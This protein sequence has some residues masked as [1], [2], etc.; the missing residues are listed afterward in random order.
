MKRTIQISFFILIISI[1]C[2][3]FA[4]S[5]SIKNNT[6]QP[7]TITVRKFLPGEL[8]HKCSNTSWESGLV[9]IKAEKIE[10]NKNIL[11][12]EKS[13]SHP[14]F[15]DWAGNVLD[16]KIEGTSKNGKPF[17][18]IIYQP[19]S[20]NIPKRTMKTYKT[21]MNDPICGVLGLPGSQDLLLGEGMSQNIFS[22]EYDAQENPVILKK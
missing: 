20:F 18:P 2:N 13:M 16:I 3:V 12:P 4:V 1:G 5:Y 19:G 17:S 14:G 8:S 7:Q 9:P 22:I 10:E 6:D 21:N 11:Q 15:F